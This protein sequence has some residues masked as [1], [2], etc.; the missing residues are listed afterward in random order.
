MEHLLLPTYTMHISLLNSDHSCSLYH[1][2]DS[3]TSQMDY[4]ELKYE[5]HV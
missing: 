2:L 4:M 5:F 1:L 3:S